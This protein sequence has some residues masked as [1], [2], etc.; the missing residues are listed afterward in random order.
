[1]PVFGEGDEDALLDI[2]GRILME[3]D[4]FVPSVYLEPLGKR[5]GKSREEETQ[6]DKNA[7]GLHAASVTPVQAFH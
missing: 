2:V 3:I 7:S 6:D 5:L 4:L 1:M